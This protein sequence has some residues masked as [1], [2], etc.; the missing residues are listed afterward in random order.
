MFKENKI[1][2]T[3]KIKIDLDGLNGDKAQKIDL[4]GQYRLTKYILLLYRFKTFKILFLN[5]TR[6]WPPS[7]AAGKCNFRISARLS[8]GCSFHIVSPMLTGTAATLVALTVSSTVPAACATA[9]SI[10]LPQ[11]MI[12]FSGRIYLSQAG[13]V[14]SLADNASPLTLTASQLTIQGITY[15][16]FVHQPRETNSALIIFDIGHH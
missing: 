8:V 1:W 4:D 6:M 3:A 15:E 16:P 12:A 9:V 5:S 13:T 2:K 14:V 10:R 7:S 11:I